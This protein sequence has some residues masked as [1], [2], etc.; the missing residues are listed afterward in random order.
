M[1]EWVGWRG[2]WGQGF[3]WAIRGSTSAKFIKWR[4]CMLHETCFL[5]Q[6]WLGLARQNWD[7]VSSECSGGASLVDVWWFSQ[8]WACT[9]Q[10]GGNKLGVIFYEISFPSCLKSP[11]PRP[12]VHCQSNWYIYK[13]C[14]NREL[15][16]INIHTH[17][18]THMHTHA[19]LIDI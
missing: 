2:W 7:R 4:V 10:F 14:C 18:F 11:P 3:S 15:P 8:V 5:C 6:A 12:A 1:P 9:F 19:Q 16:C 17:T 13:E